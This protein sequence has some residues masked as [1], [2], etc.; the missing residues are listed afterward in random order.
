MKIG[1]N[2]ILLTAFALAALAASAQAQDMGGATGGGF[3]GRH[4]QQGKTKKTETVKPKVDEK[5]YSAALKA[6][7]DKQY[8]AWHGVR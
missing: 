2:K 5:A 6:L 1:P 3:G 4:Q 7:P 8:D